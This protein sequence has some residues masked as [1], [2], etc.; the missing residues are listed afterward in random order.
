VLVPYWIT[1]WPRGGPYPLAVR[2]LGVAP[3][4][5][6]ASCLSGRPCGLLL[7]AQ[8]FGEQYEAAHGEVPDLGA[9]F[10]Y[11][12]DPTRT[13]VTVAVVP[14]VVMGGGR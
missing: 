3:V 1:R 5:G 14:T 4:A 12:I 2:V 11:C 6:A 8:A 10:C 13:L 9:S 7:W